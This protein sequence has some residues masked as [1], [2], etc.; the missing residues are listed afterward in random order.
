M[1]GADHTDSV[2]WALHVSCHAMVRMRLMH[3]R[4]RGTAC[5]SWLAVR[6]P[7]VSACPAAASSDSDP[8]SIRAVCRPYASAGRTPATLQAFPPAARASNP[9][10]GYAFTGSRCPPVRVTPAGIRSLADLVQAGP[11]AGAGDPLPGSKNTRTGRGGGGGGGGGGVKTAT[12]QE[13]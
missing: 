8:S 13:I 5:L 2:C 7:P 1:Q 6:T 10:C 3:R 4:R 12:E 9:V 11:P